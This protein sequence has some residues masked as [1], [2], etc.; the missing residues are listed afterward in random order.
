VRTVAGVH[1]A[2]LVLRGAARDEHRVVGMGLDVLLQVL[3]PLERLAAKVALMR[4]ERHVDADVGRDVVA[5]DRRGT[6]LVPLARQVEIVSALAADVLLADVL[7][8]A[9]VSKRSFI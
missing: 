1:S 5:L 2:G 6:A 9:K 7:L 3:G 4:L 8:V